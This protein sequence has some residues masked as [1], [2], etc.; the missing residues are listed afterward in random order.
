MTIMAVLCGK[1]GEELLGA[2]NR[3]WRCGQVFGALPDEGGLPPVRRP[4][5]KQHAETPPIIEAEI[6]PR[7]AT[8]VP[9]PAVR[10][11]LH[12]D[13]NPHGS[14]EI[15]SLREDAAAVTALTLGLISLPTSLL[16]CWSAI[17]ATIGLALGILGLRRA[18]RRSALIGLLLCCTAL[19]FCLLRAVVHWHT[20][21]ELQ[22]QRALYG[23][24]F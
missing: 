5:T 22:R 19:S 11:S 12:V 14:Y 16:T 4:P 3:C 17:P 20:Q 24:E 13:Q 1:C 8:H 7:R 9:S 23:D 10:A 18:R 15:P 6:A 2:V 21:Y